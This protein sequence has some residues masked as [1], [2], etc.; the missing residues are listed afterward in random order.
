MFRVALYEQGTIVRS[1]RFMAQSGTSCPIQTDKRYVAV[2]GISEG[3]F[4]I[5][6]SF[7]TDVSS[8]PGAFDAAVATDIRKDPNYEILRRGI[9]DNDPASKFRLESMGLSDQI[10]AGASRYQL[11]FRSP[12]APIRCIM[13]VDFTSSGLRILSVGRIQ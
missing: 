9:L 13:D 6:A 4:N 2:S 12:V 11:M 5:L 3:L 1:R 8:S 7:V 10:F